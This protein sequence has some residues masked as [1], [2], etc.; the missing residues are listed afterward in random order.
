MLSGAVTEKHRGMSLSAFV[1]PLSLGL[2]AIAN[3]KSWPEIEQPA[4]NGMANARSMAKLYGILA[5]GGV[6]TNGY[7]LLSPEMLEHCWIERSTA[8]T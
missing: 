8:W 4:A 6:G 7:Q 1:N 2:S 5:N 3:L